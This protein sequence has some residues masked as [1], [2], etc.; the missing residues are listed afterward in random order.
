MLITESLSTDMTDMILQLPGIEDHFIEN[1][2][3]MKEHM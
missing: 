3:G 1:W 2:N